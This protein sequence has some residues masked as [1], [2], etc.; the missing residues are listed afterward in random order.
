MFKKIYERHIIAIL[1]MLYA[2]ILA[3]PRNTT[4]AVGFM[5]ANYSPLFVQ[6]L[7]IWAVIGA[8]YLLFRRAYPVSM[9]IAS[10]PILAYTVMGFWFVTHSSNAP[11]AAFLIHLG[12]Y[13]AVLFLIG[14]RIKAMAKG[15]HD[16]DDT[17]PNRPS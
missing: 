3:D 15:V 1:L 2:V 16:D 4:G 7:A 14:L 9:I 13:T 11:I 8:A 10:V 5:I 17:L 6:A 12:V